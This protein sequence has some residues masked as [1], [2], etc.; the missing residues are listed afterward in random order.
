[1]I[2]AAFAVRIQAMEKG[3][4]EIGNYLYVV[5]GTFV[6]ALGVAL[7]LTPGRIVCGGVN[8]LATICF[9][10]L[11][12]DT[13]LVI[14]AIS[15]PLF[16]IGMRIFGPLYG[17]KSLVGTLC[18]SI[19]TTILG[20]LTSYSGFFPY[21][22]KVDTLLS[23]F[24]GG[25]L[26]GGGIGIV[27]R[28]G[29]NTGGTDIVAQIVSKYTPLSVGTALL[30]VDGLIIAVGGFA[31]G[32]ERAL[33][34]VIAMFCS[35]QMINFMVLKIGTN[36]AKTCYIFSERCRAIGDAIIEELHHG[37]TVM[38]GTGIYT[39]RKREM[40]LAVIPNQQLSTL[41]R[42]VK[43]MDPKAFVFVHEAYYAIGQGFLKLEKLVRGGS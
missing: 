40:L 34:G 41:M 6:T 29:A 21:T 27:M 11:H 17:V 5:A 20:R 7:F 33:F 14:M 32:L 28:G 2:G 16:L 23:A 19:F 13:G 35:S 3:R 18:F 26:Y 37:A 39:G 38:E 42:I 8:G 4:F 30:I 24:F 43:R 10:K 12:W 25:L 9:H 15:V 22:D 36:Q 1:M 31:F